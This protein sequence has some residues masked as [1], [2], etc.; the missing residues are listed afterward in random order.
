M[1]DKSCVNERYNIVRY[2]VLKNITIGPHFYLNRW[3]LGSNQNAI[4]LEKVT[5]SNIQV[6]LTKRKTINVKL[7]WLPA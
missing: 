6:N 1:L 4:L 2:L 7:Y 5:Q 3:T